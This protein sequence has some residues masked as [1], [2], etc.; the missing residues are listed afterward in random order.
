MKTG[1]W[2]DEGGNRRWNHL[3]LKNSPPKIGLW[4]PEMEPDADIDG[5][6]LVEDPLI[7][8]PS[9][10]GY[11]RQEVPDELKKVEFDVGNCM[12]RVGGI[13][14]ADKGKIIYSE[15]WST[16]EYRL[17]RMSVL[18]LPVDGRLLHKEMVSSPHG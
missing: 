1:Y 9:G 4:D 15:E 10:E 16:E 17:D 18:M 6:D 3:Y 12:A 5:R 13:F 2:K 7:S 11:R 14:I 8:E